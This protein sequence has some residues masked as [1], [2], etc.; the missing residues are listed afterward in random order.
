M[1]SRRRRARVLFV[2]AAVIGL[3]TALGPGAS[4]PAMHVGAQSP[5]AGRISGTIRNGTAGAAVPLTLEIRL[6]T[7]SGSDVVDSRTTSATGGAFSFAVEPDTALTYVLRTVY[8]DVPYF[9]EAVSLAP[10]APNAEREI[11]VFETTHDPPALSIASTHITVV[12]LDRTSGELTL[13]RE[14]VVRNPGD[15]VYVGDA[16]GITIRVPAVDGVIDAGPLVE[17]E[18]VR[19]EAGVVTA[20]IPLTPGDTQIVTGY[21]VR[22]DRAADRY[23]LRV[24]APLASERIEA[25]VPARFVRSVEPLEGT[26]R[27]QETTL[28]G[29]RVL[30]VARDDAGPGDSLLVDLV[31]LSGLARAENPLTESPGAAIAVVIALVTLVGGAVATMRIVRR[32]GGSAVS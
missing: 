10:D 28:R 1:R 4:P 8:D 30:V 27:D 26:S 20:A 14:D 32:R 5:P 24:T 11:T 23:R 29:E 17:D 22:Y 7:L 12:A 6:V 2:L 25:R 18:R 16:D 13:L 19:L 31:G 15:R 3:A 21:L 9:A